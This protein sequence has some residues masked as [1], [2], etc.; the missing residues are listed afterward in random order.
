MKQE[1]EEFCL[2]SFFGSNY[3]DNHF[4]QLLIV[5]CRLESVRSSSCFLFFISTLS[6][7]MVEIK[8]SRIDLCMFHALSYKKWQWEE[9]NISCDINSCKD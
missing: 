2:A 8:R 1:D 3:F 9:L 5:I 6:S 4:V 7:S